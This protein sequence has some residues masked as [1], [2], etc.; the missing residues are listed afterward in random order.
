[1]ELRGCLA[2]FDAPKTDA[3]MNEMIDERAMELDEA[4]KS[5]ARQ[6]S[7]EGAA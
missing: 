5:G 6:E 1:M 3:E 7:R 2:G 4:T